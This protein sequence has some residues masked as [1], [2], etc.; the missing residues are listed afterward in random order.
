M[1]IAERYGKRHDSVLR[2]IEEVLKQAGIDPHRF[3]GGS[4]KAAMDAP[5]LGA[6]TKAGIDALIDEAV[7]K[8]EIDALRFESVYKDVQNKDCIPHHLPSSVK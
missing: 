2:D 1:T 4:I 6:V 7:T 8:A 3:V 5:I